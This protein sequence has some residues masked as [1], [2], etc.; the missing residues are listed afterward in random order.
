MPFGRPV[1]TTSQAATLG[2][3]YSELRSDPAKMDLFTPKA[4]AKLPCHMGTEFETVQGYA[5]MHVKDL[6]CMAQP[7][8]RVLESM[9]VVSTVCLTD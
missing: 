6:Q 9:L 1:E 8:T 5:G 3:V 2:H 7:K 4:N